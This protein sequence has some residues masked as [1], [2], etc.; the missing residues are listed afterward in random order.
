MAA[1]ELMDTKAERDSLYRDDKRKYSSMFGFDFR[2]SYAF[3]SFRDDVLSETLSM[4]D[5]RITHFATSLHLKYGYAYNEA[6][7]AGRIYPGVR[8]GV[9]AG[10]NM[11]DYSRAVGTPVSLYLFQTAP[12]IRLNR[13]LSIDYEWNFGL[14]AGWK[15]CDGKTA[16]SNLI[17]GSKVNAYI[18]LGFGL[19]WKIGK[20]VSLLAGLDLTHYSDGNTSFPNPGVNLFGV[21]LGIVRT[22]GEE[23]DG[24]PFVRDSALPRYRLSYDLTGYG[25]WRKRVYRGGESPVLLAGHYAVAGMN[26]APMVDIE[27][28]FRAGVSADFQWDDSSDLKHSYISGSTTED[29]RF[30]NPRFFSQLSVGVSARAELVMPLFSVNVGIGYNFIGPEEARASYQ[31]ANLK[32]Y[33]SRSL[34]LNIGYQLQNFQRQNNLMLGLGYTFRSLRTGG[35]ALIAL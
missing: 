12:V 15:P 34:F 20:K 23:T 30:G 27:R 2:P 3:S 25:A 31:M 16:R 21:R 6:S 17:V 26:F 35:S 9:G 28:Y 13:R 14:S 8:Q 29:I 22:L 19:R 4:E 1:Q 7:E 18:N 5:A 32:V 24:T 33:I 10:V 11:F